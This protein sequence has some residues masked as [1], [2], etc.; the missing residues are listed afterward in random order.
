MKKFCATYEEYGGL[1]EDFETLGLGSI[2][3]AV[4]GH[5]RMVLDVDKKLCHDMEKLLECNNGTSN[6][7]LKCM[8]LLVQQT[9]EAGL[10][11]RY[12]SLAEIIDWPFLRRANALSNAWNTV[13]QSV[14]EL[15][16]T[17][18]DEVRLVHPKNSVKRRHQEAMQRV[19]DAHE[20]CWGKLMGIRR[21]SLVTRDFNLKIRAK[22]LVIQS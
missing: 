7:L 18:S 1:D 13:Q 4:G 2:N 5:M 19:L 16:A 8:S 12:E 17:L 21:V 9:S 11:F 14:S 20:S 3:R 10:R 15:I 6:L 22:G